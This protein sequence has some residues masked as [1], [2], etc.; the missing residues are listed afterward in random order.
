MLAWHEMASREQPHRG[1]AR[2]GRGSHVAPASSP[3]PVRAVLLVLRGRASTF[4]CTER[5]RERAATPG[6]AQLSIVPAI[7][8]GARPGP[9]RGRPRPPARRPGAHREIMR[10]RSGR[11]FRRPSKDHIATPSRPPA[12]GWISI[13][14]SSDA[15]SLR[16][17]GRPGTASSGYRNAFQFHVGAC[18]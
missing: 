18:L 14:P 1:A 17:G 12:V 2:A 13:R 16:P 9:T 15:L 11:V 7:P 6:W 5:R 8:S 10:R 3:G 4:L